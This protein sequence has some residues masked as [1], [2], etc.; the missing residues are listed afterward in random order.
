STPQA[1]AAMIPRTGSTA[2]RYCPL[3]SAPVGLIG[4][5]TG[6][7][8]GH[9]LVTTGMAAAMIPGTTTATGERFAVSIGTE[10]LSADE[11]FGVGGPC[12]VRDLAEGEYEVAVRYMITEAGSLTV[13]N[14]RLTAWSREQAP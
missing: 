2:N 5:H 11:R 8:S 14:R 10:E 13:Q 9:T 1:V 3:L 6:A 12:V 4:A 7:E